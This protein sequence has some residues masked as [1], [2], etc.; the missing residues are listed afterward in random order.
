VLVDVVDELVDEQVELGSVSRR[1]PRHRAQ[2]LHAARL[3][4]RIGRSTPLSTHKRLPRP[5]QAAE[6]DPAAAGDAAADDMGGR[7]AA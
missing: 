7:A 3:P 1:P 5:V 6:A 4:T 2:V